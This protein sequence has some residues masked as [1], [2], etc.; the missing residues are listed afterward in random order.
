MMIV[1]PENI[2]MKSEEHVKI[3]RTRDSLVIPGLKLDVPPENLLVLE[4]L[5]APIVRLDN[6]QQWPTLPIALR[7]KRELITKTVARQRLVL[8][9]SPDGIILRRAQWG[10]LL[11]SVAPLYQRA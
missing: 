7:A 1:L 6:I 5:L 9:A 11:A 8:N 10:L 3:V 4:I 2:P